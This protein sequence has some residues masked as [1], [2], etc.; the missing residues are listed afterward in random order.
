MIR[1][2]ILVAGVAL[3]CVPTVFAQQG[4]SDLR[5]ALLEVW[6]RY[7]SVRALKEYANECHPNSSAVNEQTFAKW[8]AEQN[9]S[10]A[11]DALLPSALNPTELN[12]IK[13]S[14]QT[15]ILPKLR[16]T[17]PKCV[18]S[19]QLKT[20]LAGSQ[21]DLKKI[22]AVA[23]AKVQTALSMN[24]ASAPSVKAN[25]NA[26]ANADPPMSKQDTSVESPTTTVTVPQTA[27]APSKPTDQST[28][29]GV[30]MNQSTS[31]GVGGMMTLDFD[32]Y[33]VFKDGTIC[34]DI[35]TIAAGRAGKLAARCG[36]WTRAGSGFSARWQNGKTSDL[37]GSTFYK[38]FPA[39]AGDTLSGKYSSIGGGGNTALGGTAMI[40][41]AKS[42][43]FS[44][45][46]RFQ[47]ASS[48]GGSNTGVV[49]S[50]NKSQSGTYVL[51]R[52]VI[53]LRF[54]DGNVLRT[55][56]YFF[57]ASGKKTTKSIGIGGSIYSLRNG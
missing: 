13:R 43:V 3:L 47:V 20:L 39:N 40:V 10:D 22:N 15:T 51:D 31:F 18:T 44:P 32:S 11:I 14:A 50:A 8:Q 16:Q 7:I 2:A 53:E 38:T 5:A 19:E 48:S 21:V 36:Q 25:A 29:E 56:F 49:V 26:I 17:F 55:G 12:A 57:P 6:P 23:V 24:N 1:Q 42:Y 30:Y 34:R 52:H 4:S 45:D 35:E 46:G 27:Q 9:L 28:L 54:N 33:A 41:V 37:S